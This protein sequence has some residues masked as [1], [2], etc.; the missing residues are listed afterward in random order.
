MRCTFCF[1]FLLDRWSWKESPRPT[2]VGKVWIQFL[3]AADQ[4]SRMLRQSLWW[5]ASSSGAEHTVVWV[6]HLTQRTMML[7]N[8]CCKVRSGLVHRNKHREQLATTSS[9]SWQLRFEWICLAGVYGFLILESVANSLWDARAN[10]VFLYEHLH[11][12]GLHTPKR[13]DTSVGRRP[14]PRVSCTHTVG[15]ARGA[16]SRSRCR[17]THLVSVWLVECVWFSVSS[18]WLIFTFDVFGSSYCNPIWL[19]FLGPFALQRSCSRI[20]QK[21]AKDSGLSYD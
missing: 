12:D 21:T 6:I 14:L 10:F 1:S 9:Q 11:P 7:Q 13:I 5:I 17:R 4:R 2:W 20:S 8:E 3:M 16:G 18:T 19:A 15:I